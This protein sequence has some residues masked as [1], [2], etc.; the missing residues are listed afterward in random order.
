MRKWADFHIRPHGAG[1]ETCPTLLVW[2]DQRPGGAA[3]DAEATAV[4][5]VL[6][7][8]GFVVDDVYGVVDAG[9]LTELASV[10]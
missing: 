4:A 2:H 8:L 1:I 9:Y 10:A 3:G 7:Y 5:E 6:V